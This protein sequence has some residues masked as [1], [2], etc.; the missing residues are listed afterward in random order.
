MA[1]NYDQFWDRF[2]NNWEGATL[3]A[4]DQHF[5]PGGIFI[6]IG[7]WIGPTALYAASRG[8]K[9][10]CIEADPIAAQELRRNVKANPGLS[11]LITIIDK[12]ICNRPGPINFGS[13]AGGGDSKSSFVFDAPLT[14]WTVETIT[15]KELFNLA[16]C[17]AHPLIK[18]DIEGGEYSVF[19]DLIKVFGG[20]RPTV[21]LSLHPRLIPCGYLEIRKLSR[22]VFEACKS[23]NATRLRREPRTLDKLRSAFVRTQLSP[24]IPKGTWLFSHR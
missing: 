15:P 22:D 5:T 9:T 16:S 20:L 8:Q 13:N 10:I 1:G 2:E 4:F 18:M 6:D 19:P 21:V 3:R 7:S 24:A 14:Q 12:A 11:P 23:Y 17:S